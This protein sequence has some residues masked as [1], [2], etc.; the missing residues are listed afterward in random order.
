[1]LSTFM[2]KYYDK[3]TNEL[4]K[5]KFAIRLSNA[6]YIGP[7]DNPSQNDF[8][9]ITLGNILD[10]N[11][12]YQDEYIV[13]IDGG[14]H[15]PKFMIDDSADTLK[16]DRNIIQEK[17]QRIFI[18]SNIK[19]DVDKNVIIRLGGGGVFKVWLNNVCVFCGWAEGIDRNLI[20]ASINKGNNTIIV[21]VEVSIRNN[22]LFSAQI[23]TL[24]E[25][26]CLP[27]YPILHS[28][29]KSNVENSFE[30]VDETCHVSLHKLYRFVIRKKDFTSTSNPKINIQLKYNNKILKEFDGEFGV[31]YNIDCDK[32]RNC[33]DDVYVMIHISLIDNDE[34]L[35]ENTYPLFIRKIDSYLKNV[36]EKI[37]KISGNVLFYRYIMNML[38]DLK[39]CIS[40]LNI[41]PKTFIEHS[42]NRIRENFI[43]NQ[44]KSIEQCIDSVNK[45]NKFKNI[46]YEEGIHDL[47]FDSQIDNTVKKM[48]VHVPQNYNRNNKYPLIVLVLANNISYMSE[49]ESNCL[50]YKRNLN[51]FTNEPC[52]VAFVPI[53]GFTMGS[54]IGDTAFFEAVDLIKKH[55]CIDEDRTYLAGNSNGAYTTWSIA[56]NHPDIFAAI[57]TDGGCPNKDNLKNINHVPIMNIVGEMDKIVKNAYFVPTEYYKD[58]NIHYNSCLIK[59][60]NHYTANAYFYK[61]M[62]YYINWLLQFRRI[63]LPEQIEFRTERMIY[64]KSHCLEI[65]GITEGETFSEIRMNL[66]EQNIHIETLNVLAFS[67]D[68]SYFDYGAALK[69][70]INGQPFDL[71]NKDKITFYNVF[72]KY[73]KCD[74]FI[75]KH[76]RQGMGFLYIYINNFKVI[77]PSHSNNED[78]KIL[79]QIADKFSKPKSNTVREKIDVN[80]DV[81]YDNEYKYLDSNVLLIDYNLSNTVLNKI[82]DHLPIQ[83]YKDC[84]YYKNKRL[85]G[86]YSIMCICTI[87]QSEVAIISS[88]NP[89]HFDTN[90]FIR[91]FIIPSYYNGFHDFLNND[92]IIYNDGHYYTIYKWGDDLVKKI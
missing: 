30:L 69:L 24:T 57:I 63:G 72:D 32:L 74:D 89:R 33:V 40:E 82:L 67:I 5:E 62:P 3:I 27:E 12:L 44:I 90:F 49:S 55:Y 9:N 50:V 77:L 34:I 21:E 6:C 70:Y 26:T 59:A 22:S 31:T 20:M 83:L 29:I 14:I 91:N 10:M 73:E 25:Q 56:Q 36:I 46:F 1:M 87:E 75:K 64:N 86:E 51:D 61:N 84:V 68:L 48:V 35:S 17:N 13:D 18:F 39:N 45:G 79:N 28:Y 41:D 88:N 43:I 92:A 23:C 42:T 7:I 58:K 53:R 85:N 52:I 37:N 76:Q 66:Y 19:S 78:L 54:Y 38:E 80:Y 60:G 47:Y 11:R 71:D 2:K 4:S 8:Y 81:M 16:F 15:M 65:L